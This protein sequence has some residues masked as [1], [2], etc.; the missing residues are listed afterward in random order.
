MGT[1]GTPLKFPQ[2]FIDEVRSAADIVTV[3]S[4]TVSLRKAGNSYKG[5]CPFH[6]EKTPSFNVM[7]ERG[8]FNC[9]GCGVGGDVFKFVELQEKVGFSEAVRML[10]G[11][12]GIPIPELEATGEQRESAAER[13]ALVK[14]HELALGYFREQLAS[15]AGAKVREYLAQDRG[16]TPETIDQLQLGYAPPGR[17]VLKQR[18]LKAGFRPAQLVTSGLVVRRDDGTE[19]DKFRN[20]LMVPIMRDTGT[21]IAFGGRAL[22]ADQVPKYLNSPETPIYSKSRTLYGLNLTKGHVRKGN[23]ALI[24]E[25]YF[26]FAQVHQ[27]GGF[28]VVA[29]CG[30]ALTSAQAQM[31]RRFASKAVLCYDPD[32]AGQAAAERSSELLV[33]ENFDVN[34]VQLPGGDDPD[35]FI[36]KQGREAF[37]AQL[38]GSRPYLE[39][40]LDRAGA[41]HD[42]TRDDSR[43]EFLRKMLGVAARIPD[44]AARDQ[45]ADRL[46]HKARVTEGVVRAEIRKAAGARKTELPAERLPTL[47]GRVRKAEKALIWTLVHDPSAAVASLSQLEVADLQGLSTENI[48]RTARDLNVR[49]ED[50]PTTLMERLSTQEAE[51][52]ASVAAEPS[53]PA[54]LPDLCVLALKY[55]RLERELADVQRELNRLQNV[56]DTGPALM[57]LLHQKQQMI[58][59]L[60]AM[61]PPKELQ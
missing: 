27:A 30:T 52:L 28:P 34:V 19:V 61:K 15:P 16:L 53:P 42:L 35:T 11:R 38:K 25:G 22:E 13:E 29:T 4:D 45:F 60:E 23:F 40:L 14:M 47:Q 48:L 51:L 17:D 49:A 41:E 46:A 50:V 58:R 2:S 8:F 37:V 39:F 24:V 55:V 7:R 26:D 5:L 9:F 57:D 59:A 32:R 54:V 56:G 20:R 43:R 31:L 18:L 21:V 36:Q 12:F 33:A 44:P 6:S 1:S 3:I 10:A